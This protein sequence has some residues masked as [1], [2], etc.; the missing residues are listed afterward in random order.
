[1]VAAAVV[2]VAGADVKVVVL[3]VMTA[4]VAEVSEVEA[5]VANVVVGRDNRRVDRTWREREK[6]EK[7]MVEHTRERKDVSRW[8][9]LVPTRQNK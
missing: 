8:N 7:E 6:G 9:S 2:V 1:M 3:V 5:E 4:D